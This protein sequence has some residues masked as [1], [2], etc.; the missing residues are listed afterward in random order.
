[1][2]PTRVS[3]TIS[4]YNGLGFASVE[5]ANNHKALGINRSGITEDLIYAVEKPDW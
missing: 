3:L 5:R 4:H 1:M 2:K